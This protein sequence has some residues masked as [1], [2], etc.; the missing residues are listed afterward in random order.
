MSLPLAIYN[1][2][3]KTTFTTLKAASAVFPSAKRGKLAKFVKMQAETFADIKNGGEAHK[4]AWFH[5]SSMGEYQ[6]ARPVMKELKRLYGVTTVLTFFSPTGVEAIA[7]LPVDKSYADCVLPLPLDI[8]RNVCRFINCVK[9]DIAIFLVSEFWPNYLHIL[10]KRAIPTLLYSAHFRPQNPNS[11]SFRFKKIMARMFDTIAVHDKESK[12]NLTAVGCDDVRL[13][14]DPLFD[15]AL[16][17]KNEKYSNPVIEEFCGNS[18]D[19]LVAGSLHYD[20]DMHLLVALAE[21]FPEL[22]VIVVPHEIDNEGINGLISRLPGSAVLYSH[23]K[24][25]RDFKDARFLIIDY[26][27]E[28]ARIYRYGSAAYIGGG[29]TRLLHSVVE[30]AVYGL[31]ISFGPR[32]ER[33]NIARRMIERG[34]ATSVTTPQDIINWWKRLHDSPDSLAK[35]R[36]EAIEFCEEQK[37]GAADAA[38]IIYGIIS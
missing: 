18:G 8:P 28:L 5:A 34:I 9:P 33:K 26:V 38:K 16:A 4:T 13:L 10:K 12:D 17:V 14:G 35:V 6:I 23:V 24:D 22:K 37:G 2:A 19:V 15:N 30:P 1:I 31:P 7:K 27:G 20:E 25:T 29:F 36:Q 3:L 21:A 11:V 32:I